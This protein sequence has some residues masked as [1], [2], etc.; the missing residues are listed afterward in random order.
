LSDACLSDFNVEPSEA[1]ERLE[2]FK[3]SFGYLR[4][5]MLPI[6]GKRGQ[7][8]TVIAFSRSPGGVGFKC[9]SIM[10]KQAR[11]I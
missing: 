5:S 2:R 6:T 4:L 1:I 11:F 3:Q 8:A 10:K 7:L 9:I